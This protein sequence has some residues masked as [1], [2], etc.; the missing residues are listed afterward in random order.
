MRRES[1]GEREPVLAV[2]V[3]H[4]N[5]RKGYP[6]G[7]LAGSSAGCSRSQVRSP[8]RHRS[9]LGGERAGRAEILRLAVRRDLDTVRNGA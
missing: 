6:G 2:W 3:Y 4:T 5:L 8:L 7:M 9:S 1:E